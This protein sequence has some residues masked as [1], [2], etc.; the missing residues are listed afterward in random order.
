[1]IHRWIFGLAVW[2]LVCA[3]A[4]SASAQTVAS[5]ICDF[6]QRISSAK[7]VDFTPFK[8]RPTGN[9][10]FAGT[11]LP[12]PG[13]DCGVSLQSP[14]RPYYECHLMR[15]NSMDEAIRIYQQTAAALRTCY[16]GAGVVEKAHDEPTQDDPE[17]FYWL[18]FN[19]A[20]FQLE[21]QMSRDW[22]NESNLTLWVR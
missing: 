22:D 4:T 1:M 11:L 13:A 15:G 21:L 14:N 8:G 12:F 9:G 18:E 10:T 20:G 3:S 19:L 16:P 7:A 17:T 6:S 2:M 5:S